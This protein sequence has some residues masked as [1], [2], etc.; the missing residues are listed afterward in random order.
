[1]KPADF[2]SPDLPPCKVT[3]VSRNRAHRRCVI[4]ANNKAELRAAD[5]RLWLLLLFFPFYCM[6]LPVG[7]LSC[8]RGPDIVVLSSPAIRKKNVAAPLS[9]RDCS[10]LRRRCAAALLTKAGGSAAL[11]P[12]DEKSDD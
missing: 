6:M 10:L 12:N 1:M 3:G 4:S 7:S 2:R 5:R 8:T 11:G 9:G